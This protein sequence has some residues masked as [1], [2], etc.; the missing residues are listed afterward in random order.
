LGATPYEKGWESAS[1]DAR[2]FPWT[3]DPGKEFS[4]LVQEGMTPSVAIQSATLQAA[5]LM[6]IDD[7]VGVVEPGKLAD[8]VAV[9]G[10]PL[11][12]ISLMEKVDFVMKDGVVCRGP[13]TKWQSRR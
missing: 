8:I 2:A 6:H 7:K 10:N 13:Q 5:K 9:P 12:E 11:D 1:V 3:T 4:V